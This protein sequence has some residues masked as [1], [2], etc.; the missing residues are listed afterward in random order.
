MP[1]KSGNCVLYS[2]SDNQLET[3]SLGVAYLVA[4]QSGVLKDL[5]HLHAM[6]VAKSFSPQMSLEESQGLYRGWLDVVN[7]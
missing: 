1:C 4:L 7:Q 6:A 2:T 3:A 5:E